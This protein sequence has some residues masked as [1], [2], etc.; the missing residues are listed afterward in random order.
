VSNLWGFNS[1]QKPTFKGRLTS[2]GKL[3]LVGEF[4]MADS[5]SIPDL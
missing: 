3:L 2:Q 4:P 1:K 5:T